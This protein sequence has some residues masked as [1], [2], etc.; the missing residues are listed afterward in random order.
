MPLISLWNCARVPRYCNESGWR[1]GTK[2][3]SWADV[4]NCTL[5]DSLE[6]HTRVSSKGIV[7]HASLL[8]PHRSA[9]VLLGSFDVE[10]QMSKGRVTNGRYGWELTFGE[11]VVGSPTMATLTL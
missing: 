9:L 11:E 3:A 10:L 6:V 4:I 7:T 8:K 5:P 1:E 2:N